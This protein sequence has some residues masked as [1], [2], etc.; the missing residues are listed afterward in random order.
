[1]RRNGIIFLMMGLSTVCINSG[2]SL[3]DV[4]QND[5]LRILYD[6]AVKSV[7]QEVKQEKSFNPNLTLSAHLMP[8][9]VLMRIL[10]DRFQIGLVFSEKLFSKNITAEFK[11]TNLKDVLNVISRQLD[12][13]IVQ[14]GNTYYIG[15]LRPEDRGILV[16]K[17]IG[18]EKDELRNSVNAALSDKGKC[19]IVG[20]GV[21]TVV[22]HE[23]VL[24]RVSE[25][26]DYL[27]DLDQP[28]W[29][30]QLAFVI[31]KR[32]ALAEGGANVKTSGTISY[33]I[34]E[35]RV[36][37]KDFKIDGL[38]NA[39]MSSSFADIYSSPM[40]L[41]REGSESS[42]KNGRRVPIPRKT[43][44]D[45]G[46]VT[47]SGYDYVDVGFSV[48]CSVISSRVGGLLDIE[49]SKSDIESYVESAPVTAQNVYKIKVDLKPLTPYLLGELQLFKDLNSQDEVLMLGKSKGKSVVQ[50]WGQIY[51]ITPGTKEIS[52]ASPELKKIQKSNP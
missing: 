34:S 31:L 26:L 45:Y 25:L 35:N 14:V 3:R 52:P 39:A 10:S 12:T 5:P 7:V 20:N 50:L 44:S 30:V 9:S 48:R 37:L 29:I 1:M 46:T 21:I 32:D 27:D 6:P 22:D 18:F 49:I 19:S 4:Q 16:R 13:D 17:V 36:D 40:L 41:V 47:T 42:W 23:S 15:G 8:F 28:V 11:E 51:R 2:C 33:N 24:R 43:V 38:F